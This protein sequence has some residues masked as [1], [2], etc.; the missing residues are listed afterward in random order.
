LEYLL[1]KVVA[2]MASINHYSVSH[3]QLQYLNQII[4]LTKPLDAIF[5]WVF[6]IV[7]KHLTALRLPLIELA[8]T[9]CLM[10]VTSV[11]LGFAIGSVTTS[12]ESAMS[13]G[14]P[15]MVIFMIVGV[16]NP[17]GVSS[18]EPP[19]QVMAFLRN[20]SPIRWAIEAVV[21]AEFR[22]MNFSQADRGR[23]G[24]LKNLVGLSLYIIF[25]GVSIMSINVF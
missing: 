24:N 2:E 4:L 16:I 12:V 10:T 15:V 1:A 17:S 19:N 14:V 9:Y 6:A 3:K 25:L 8:K 7:L 20:L 11:S 22:D 5:S 21:T 23:W 18:D 13:V